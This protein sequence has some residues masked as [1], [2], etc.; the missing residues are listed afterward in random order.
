L[1][2]TDDN[3]KLFNPILKLWNAD[4]GAMVWFGIAEH[5]QKATTL[6]KELSYAA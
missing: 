1:I 4:E 5:L 3:C 2:L 6:K